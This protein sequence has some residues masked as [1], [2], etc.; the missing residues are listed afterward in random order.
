M[1]D[2]LNWRGASGK[3]YAYSR[4]GLDW[5]PAADQDGNYIFAKFA[6]GT[7]YAVYVGQGD[8]RSRRQAALDE[9]CV[10]KK[11]A[12][13]FHCHRNSNKDA[14]LAEESDVLEGNPEAYAPTGCNERAGG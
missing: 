6:G 8:L 12:T 9:G 2:T 7:Y 4:H 3:T 13:Q 5:V 10:Q 14:R 11:G 1:A